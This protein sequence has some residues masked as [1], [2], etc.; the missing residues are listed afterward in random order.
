MM[1]LP[2]L[3][4]FFPSCPSCLDNNSSKQDYLDYYTEQWYDL[5]DHE[6]GISKTELMA[7]NE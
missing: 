2:I 5:I 6:E 7:T 1:F 4:S 3:S